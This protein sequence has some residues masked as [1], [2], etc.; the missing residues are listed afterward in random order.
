[1]PVYVVILL[2]YQCFYQ[3][4]WSALLSTGK[5]NFSLPHVD[6]TKNTGD[7]HGAWAWRGIPPSVH[8]MM[9]RIAQDIDLARSG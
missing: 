8:E 4:P 2:L 9:R 1:M 7:A 6:L 5:R 3:Q